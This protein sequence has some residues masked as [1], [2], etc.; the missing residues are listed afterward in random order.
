MSIGKTKKKSIVKPKVKEIILFWEHAPKAKE[1]QTII[2]QLPQWHP[3][4]DFQAALATNERLPSGSVAKCAEQFDGGAV[5]NRLV[6]AIND[7]GGRIENYDFESIS[8]MTLERVLDIATIQIIEKELQ[9]KYGF[10]HFDYP[11]R[12][13]C[14]LIKT[15]ISIC[16]YALILDSEI[17]LSNYNFHTPGVKG[18]K[19]STLF[20]EAANT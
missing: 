14:K 18:Y 5:A 10:K 16:H 17:D 12:L 20:W 3:E 6:N 13:I 15:K 9:K 4:L 1:A 7:D 2:D 11:N 8:K 19:L